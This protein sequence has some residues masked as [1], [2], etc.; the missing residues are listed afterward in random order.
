MGLKL[1]CQKVKI[2]KIFSGKK[3]L[4]VEKNLM[5]LFFPP[6]KSNRFQIEKNLILI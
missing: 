6:P 2:G 5:Y 1:I 4:I 3:I